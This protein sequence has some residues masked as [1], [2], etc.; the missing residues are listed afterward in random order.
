MTSAPRKVI[1]MPTAI[2]SH[3]QNRFFHIVQPT[4]RLVE[5]FSFEHCHSHCIYEWSSPFDVVHFLPWFSRSFFDLLIDDLPNEW[6]AM[7][8]LNNKHFSFLNTNFSRIVN[9]IGWSN[10]KKKKTK[11]HRRYKEF[12]FVYMN[13]IDFLIL[14][15]KKKNNNNHNEEMKKRLVDK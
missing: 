9:I 1:K 12:N 8:N 13:V 5:T 2:F 14:T 11:R 6:W 7:F 15:L 4:N 3:R 10:P